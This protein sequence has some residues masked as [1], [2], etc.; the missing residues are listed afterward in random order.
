VE[1]LLEVHQDVPQYIVSDQD[2]LRQILI[3]LLGNA[4]KFTFEGQVVVS[5]GLEKEKGEGYLEFKILDTG[6][7]IKEEDKKKLFK[8]YGRL[9]QEDPKTNTQGIGFGLE[10]SNQLA[11][12]LAHSDFEDG[13]K[14]ES[15]YGEGSAFSFIIKDLQVNHDHSLKDQELAFDEPHV[16]AEEIENISIK[17]SPYNNFASTPLLG[18]EKDIS[19][20]STL[21]KNMPSKFSSTH[22]LTPKRNSDRYINMSPMSRPQHNNHKLG[23]IALSNSQKIIPNLVAYGSS[24]PAHTPIN[25]EEFRSEISFLTPTGDFS[26]QKSGN[27]PFEKSRAL[28]V[29]DNPFNL[30]V[31]KHLLEGLNFTVE[32]ALNGKLGVDLAKTA[33][34]TQKKPF[35]L[36][37][38]DLQMPVMDGYEATKVLREMIVEGEIPDLHIIAVSAN[39]SEDDKRRCK[40]VGMNDHLAKPLNEK[41]LKEALDRIFSGSSEDISDD[42]DDEGFDKVD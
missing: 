37:L 29:D 40:E 14:V 22:N 11:K 30:L 41:H 26:L 42:D 32:T 27:L 15:E 39:D 35:I 5:V 1:L 33:H 24:S 2:R 34:V 3:N 12:L 31:A 10:I 7:G 20:K 21:L 16:F 18:S 17:M 4:F 23:M 13:I 19:L 8:M 38:M 25:T 6:I 36:V 9:E 28:I